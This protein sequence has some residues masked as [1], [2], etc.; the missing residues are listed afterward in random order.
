[1]LIVINN[2]SFHILKSETFNKVVLNRFDV[3]LKVAVVRGLLDDYGIVV[4]EEH[5][6]YGETVKQFWSYPNREKAF[7]DFEA[8]KDEWKKSVA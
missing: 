1:M 5:E 8:I 6:I 2:R 7:D 4:Y 3:E